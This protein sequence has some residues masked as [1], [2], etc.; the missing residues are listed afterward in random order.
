MLGPTLEG[1][2]N[3]AATGAIRS[4]PSARSF[5]NPG[6]PSGTKT[7]VPD[8]QEPPTDTAVPA[9]ESPPSFDEDAHDDAKFAP[10]PRPQNVFR[11]PPIN[12]AKYHVVG[13]SLDK[14]HEEQRARPTLGQPGQ[15][16]QPD[17][18][19]PAPPYVMAAPY[20]PLKE[21]SQD[22]HPM[23]TRKGFKKNGLE[24]GSKLGWKP[25]NSACVLGTRMGLATPY[26]Q[27]ILGWQHVRLA[28]D[29]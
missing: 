6:R 11:M 4:P 1:R 22:Q 13:D 9:V 29:G 15:P 21:G 25:W 19:P 5:P 16:N 14:M 3:N 27:E 12:W 10:L 24:R 8:T 17:S 26:L 7:E 18:G 28:R 2:I 23:Q 20:S